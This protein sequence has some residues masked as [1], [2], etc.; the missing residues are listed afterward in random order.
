MFRVLNGFLAIIVLIVVLKWA[1]P[2]E[3]VELASQ[4]LIR[5]LTLVRDLLQQVNLPQ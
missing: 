3:A 5:I 4:I 1:L 2:A